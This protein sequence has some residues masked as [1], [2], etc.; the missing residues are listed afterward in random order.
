MV[1][2]FLLFGYQRWF[3]YEAQM[4]IPYITN[5]SLICWMYPV[6][7]I[8]GASSSLAVAEWLFG[9][10][11]FEILEQEIRTPWRHRIVCHVHS[12]YHNYPFTKRIGSGGWISSNVRH[13]RA[14]YCCIFLSLPNLSLLSPNSVEG[15]SHSV[16]R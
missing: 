8:R 9:A 1:I 4:L 13:V 11:L 14:R 6:F 12:D 2:I 5:G 7:G 16:Y 15:L 3:E 10:L